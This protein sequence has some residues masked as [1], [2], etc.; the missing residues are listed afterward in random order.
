ME[1]EIDDDVWL[2]PDLGC[3]TLGEYARA[4]IPER[5]GLRPNT[6]QVYRYV[7]ARHIEPTFGNRAVVSIRETHIRRWR[8]DLLDS[9]VSAASVAKSYR[10]F[11]AIMTTAVD[12]G[13]VRSA[14]R[15][16]RRGACT[17][18]GRRYPRRGPGRRYGLAAGRDRP[19]C[20]R[21][22]HPGRGADPGSRLLLH[23]DARRRTT[24]AGCPSSPAC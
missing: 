19:R 14:A 3:A 7:L 15:A 16:G 9:G 20:A 4:W 8:S 11:K 1:S 24:L 13:I 22:R 6:V 12:D 2:S 21:C 23:S 5:P 17:G 10:L 18:T